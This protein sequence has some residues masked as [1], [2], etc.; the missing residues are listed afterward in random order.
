M[1]SISVVIILVCMLGNLFACERQ[2]APVVEGKS[3]TVTVPEYFRANH[4]FG[5]GLHEFV[6]LSKLEGFDALQTRDDVAGFAAGIPGAIGFTLHP[7]FEQGER[8]ASAVL[9]YTGL[10]ST[11]SSWGLYLFN[12]QEAEK[13]PG[14]APRAEAVAAAEAKI[15]GKMEEAKE[16]IEAAGG[17]GVRLTGEYGERK[18]LA[19]AVLRLNG[20][21]AHSDTFRSGPCGSCR[22][23][24]PGGTP[25]KCGHGIVNKRHWSC[26]GSTDAADLFCTYWEQI[27]ALDDMSNAE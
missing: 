8:Y 20:R 15:S 11:R 17:K 22:T 10:S 7:R 26:C 16:L 9:W 5:S 14:D 2:Q 27:K 23:V 6:D 13:N 12:S 1:R 19:L 3:G 24:I 4:G 25:T 21:F 18:V